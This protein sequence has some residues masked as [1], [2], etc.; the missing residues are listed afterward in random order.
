MMVSREPLAGSA[1]QE[2][3]VKR[4][5]LVLDERA[6][7][8][9]Q[10]LAAKLEISEFDV[11]QVHHSC[12]RRIERARLYRGQPLILDLVPRTKVEFA[13]TNQNLARV[14]AS[15]DT[16]VRPDQVVVFDLECISN[17]S[18]DSKPR[19]G[20]LM[21]LSQEHGVQLESERAG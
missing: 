2:A 18:G 20:S 8:A 17:P 14:I 21:P 5:E 9:F 11:A 4:I 16:V 10:E 7:D 1:D 15:I 3:E 12:S 19:P 13:V 6:F